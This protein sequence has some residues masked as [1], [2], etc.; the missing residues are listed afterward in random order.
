MS[1]WLSGYVGTVS[2]VMAFIVVQNALD[3]SK[4]DWA[5]W[6]QAI[7]SVGAV[8]A[9]IWVATIETR[10][11]RTEAV[12]AARIT[13]SE[14][15]LRLAVDVSHIVQVERLL[16][17]GMRGQYSPTVVLSAQSSLAALT[18]ATK[19]E[20][21]ALI[22][23]SIDVA[24]SLSQA[25]GRRHLAVN[26]IDKLVTSILNNREGDKSMSELILRAQ[27]KGLLDCLQM[28]RRKCHSVSAPKI[29]N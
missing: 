6:A 14:L 28:V 4:A 27:V 8:F 11:R 9:A 7:E 16:S 23:L 25:S 10:R 5:A 29:I 22:P 1:K 19:E 12:A 21:L 3:L 20:Q 15:E 2:T 18:L 24:Q 13:A 17:E 26:E